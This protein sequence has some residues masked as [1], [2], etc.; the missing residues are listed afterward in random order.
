MHNKGFILF[1]LA[2]A[3][4]L[5]AFNL[6]QPAVDGLKTGMR[7]TIA[8]LQALVAN[9]A[10]RIREAVSAVRGLGG[11]IRENQRMAEELVHLRRRLMLLESVAEQNR[12]LAQLLDF[13]RSSDQ[14]LIPCEVIGRDIS[15]WWQSVRLGKGRASGIESGQA[16]VT[17]D[18]LVG[19][20]TDVSRH[21]AEVLLISDPSSRVSGRIS[22]TGTFGIVSGQ[23]VTLSGRPLCRMEFIDK[24]TP[25]RPGDEVI[26]SG[27][28]G[29]YSR[30]LLI[31]Y[32]EKVY[33][34]D[35]GLYQA[36]DIYPR[37]DL[38][39]LTHVFV[40]SALSGNAA[41]RS[42]GGQQ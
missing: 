42:G 38:N 15:G 11:I 24:N 22:R 28:G 18:G 12:R 6:P 14:N 1:L 34:D 31:G 16:V 37:A 7:E 36:A 41:P 23:G 13:Q 17:S 33:T 19:R 39:R 29:V 3:L 40:V 25:I 27:L 32:V 8:P 5:V 2:G 4:L 9:S 10:L 20:T 26:T 21:T 35:S 30:G